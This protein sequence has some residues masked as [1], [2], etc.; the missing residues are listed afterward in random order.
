MSDKTKLYYLKQ[1]GL[2]YVSV[3]Q[4]KVT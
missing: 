4:L 1:F 3:L 2:N